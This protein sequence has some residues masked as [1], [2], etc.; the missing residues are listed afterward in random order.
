MFR[1]KQQ[2]H[3]FRTYRMMLSTQCLVL[4]S[5]YTIQ[6]SIYT[7]THTQYHS[8]ILLLFWM[9]IHHI[10]RNRK[11]QWYKFRILLNKYVLIF[12]RL[13]SVQPTQFMHYKHLYNEA[14]FLF[15]ESKFVLKAILSQL[16]LKKIKTCSMSF[17]QS[18]PE[19]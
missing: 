8:V 4:N 7:R 3:L 9:V 18:L 1:H 14:L 17:F 16:H 5:E 11:D 2:K 19:S 6:N 13:S 10:T 15:L 12:L